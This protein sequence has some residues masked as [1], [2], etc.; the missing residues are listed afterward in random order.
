VSERGTRTLRIVLGTVLLGL[1]AVLAWGCQSLAGIEDRT[2]G[3][4]GEFCDTVMANCIGPNQVYE[5]REKC[6]ALCELMPVGDPNEPQGT[7]TV[8]CR[9]REAR[10]ADTADGE[11]LPR[12]CRSAG[13]E[14]VDCGGGCENYCKLY[15]QACSEVQCGSTQNCID[16]CEALVDR[17]AFD[18]HEDHDGDTLQC[19]VVHL[20][21]ATIQPTPHCSHSQLLAPPTFCNWQ[22][23]EG[24]PNTERPEEPDCDQY[25]HMVAV[26]CTGDAAI[27]ESDEQCQATCEFLDPGEFSDT[28]ENTRG[29][30]IYHTY[31]SL[32]LPATHCPH[33]GPPGDGHCGALDEGNCES[34]CLLASRICPTDFASEFDDADECKAACADLDGASGDSGYSVNAA[35]EGGDNLGC[36]FLA[37]TRA[38]TGES[39]C[40]A[41]F[42]AAP[43][44]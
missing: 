5:T 40:D 35:N 22:I 37:L 25:C 2:L 3:P 39:T 6:L 20:S 23:D 43:C 38:A 9:M 30:R 41:A 19:R 24:E 7:P 27:Y 28:K 14:G 12:R 32:C 16:K 15:E 21:N 33:A 36:R 26:A 29:C 4:C 10:L 44:D 31:N 8:A 1:F 18:L 34:Y 13:P 17:G 11:A 42:G